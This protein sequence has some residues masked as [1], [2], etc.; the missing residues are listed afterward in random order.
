MSV[1][2]YVMLWVQEQFTNLVQRL[3]PNKILLNISKTEIVT[4][5]SH[6]KQITKHL[7]FCLSSQKIIPKNH[8]KYLGIIIDEHLIFKEYM[9]QLSQKL[10]KTNNQLAKLR[11]HFSSSLLKTINFALFI[12]HLHYAAEIWGQGSNNEVDMIYRTQNKALQ[13]ISFKDSDPLYAKH[14]L[15]KLKN[16]ITLNKCLYLRSTL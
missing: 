5:K 9:A 13:I 14:K 2:V 16:I 12:S 8:T 11:Y 6:S 10:N 4:F 7:N 15:L 1:S 3:R